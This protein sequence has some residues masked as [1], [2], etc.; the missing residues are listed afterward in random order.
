MEDSKFSK[1][2]ASSKE[3][4]ICALGGGYV[5]NFLTSGGLSK[6]FAV[7]S[8]I[9][10]YFK[11]N[12]FT[13]ND[14]NMFTNMKEEKTVDVKDITGTG[15]I[16]DNALGVLI[17]S[18]LM[19]LISVVIY[20]TFPEAINSSFIN[21]TLIGITISVWIAYI[22]KRKTFFQITFSGGQILFKKAW[23]NESEIQEFQR[24]IRLAK[25]AYEERR[26]T[27]QFLNISG[28]QEKPGNV[29]DEIK[30]YKE[31]LDTGVINAEEFELAK[32]KLLSKL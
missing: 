25:D 4:F 2:F 15:F 32:N 1:L 11:G 8:D 26:E 29:T 14:K 20:I 28:N 31:L 17:S 19:T 23:F 12:C 24:N 7:L 10:V 21:V 5:E 18:I 9:R 16:I 27:Q 22:L 13:R 30:K 3:K 6:G